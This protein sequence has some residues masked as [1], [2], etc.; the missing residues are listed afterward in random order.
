MIYSANPKLNKHLKQTN[1][2]LQQALFKKE[3]TDI[4]I[5]EETISNIVNVEDFLDSR[6]HDPRGILIG[7]KGAG[8][9]LLLR[10]RAWLNVNKLGTR[11]IPKKQNDQTLKFELTED[12]NQDD[13]KKYVQEKDYRAIWDFSIQYFILKRL[14]IDYQEELPIYGADEKNIPGA[15]ILKE[16]V[17]DG[18][19]ISDLGRLVSILLKNR[20][21]LK[22]IQSTIG[23]LNEVFGRLDASLEQPVT[24]YI[25]NVDQAFLEK[26]KFKAKVDMT[27]IPLADWPNHTKVVDIW[28]NAN[29]SFL[30][31]IWNMNKKYSF[32]SLFVAVRYEAWNHFLLSGMA[33]NIA[34]IEG[35]IVHIKYEAR[36]LRAL[37]DLFVSS[38]KEPIR[39]ILT[40]LVNTERVHPKA[41]DDSMNRELFKDLMI[42]HTFGNPRDLV[43][44]LLELGQRVIENI[45]K[46]VSQD[47]QQYGYFI[48]RIAHE[49]VFK[50]HFANECLPCFPHPELDDFLNKHRKNYFTMDDL[51]AEEIALIT[52]LYRFGLVGIVDATDDNSAYIQKF[53]RGSNFPEAYLPLKE[54]S[55][56][57]LHPCI[58]YPLRQINEAFYYPHC[59]IGHGLPFS[60][61]RS[62]EYYLPKKCPR[63]G[64]CAAQIQEKFTS[65]YTADFSINAFGKIPTRIQT[66]YTALLLT[67]SSEQSGVKKLNEFLANKI[68]HGGLLSCSRA[69]DDIRLLE[70]NIKLRIILSIAVLLEVYTQGKEILPFFEKVNPSDPIQAIYNTNFTQGCY[71]R[72]RMIKK[73]EVIDSLSEFEKEVIRDFF[74]SNQVKDFVDSSKDQIKHRLYHQIEDIKKRV[75]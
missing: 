63:Q 56:Y 8:K 34:N 64:N 20:S 51:T 66:A 41:K 28:L 68:A 47:I 38:Q 9:S 70:R 74:Y 48:D 50:K 72:A 23:Q 71:T 69:K 32:I 27:S 12:L 52:E 67:A 42:R 26:L 49:I 7:P 55:F 1:L 18:L 13:L 4:K 39:E 31:A 61:K 45:E 44:L 43:F 16:M 15:A 30:R 36:Q 73:E 35:N 53:E 24:I 10:C 29:I 40:T 59:I 62:L 14:V 19:Y 21:F 54:S 17:P 6:I 5:T 75:F 33:I 3:G 11:Y 46:E 57:L 65:F 2:T 37:I 58:D 25:D 60:F 22:D